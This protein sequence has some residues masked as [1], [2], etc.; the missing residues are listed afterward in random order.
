MLVI[1]W[2][3]IMAT[4]LLVAWDFW[5]GRKDVAEL[6]EMGVYLGKSD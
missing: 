2:V 1:K 6:K 4:V 3:L 5:L